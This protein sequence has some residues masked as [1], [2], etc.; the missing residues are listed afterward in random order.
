MKFLT[1]VIVVAGLVTLGGCDGAPAGRNGP[2]AD[3]NQQRQSHAAPLAAVEVVVET[4]TPAAELQADP[5]LPEHQQELLRIAWE[6]STA[7]P[8]NPHLRERARLQED[9]ALHAI[10]LGQL[11]LVR[12]GLDE[13]KTMRRL[14]VVAELALHHARRG[15][16][17]IAAAYGRE[18]EG[19]L[20]TQEFEIWD[21]ARLEAR[22]IAVHGWLAA[23][24]TPV[25]PDQAANAERA[26]Y[27]QSPAEIA[28]ELQRYLQAGGRQ[29]N[30]MT[31][32]LL[33]A[34]APTG[35]MGDEVAQELETQLRGI[36]SKSSLPQR[37]TML[38][39]LAAYEA[40]H[41]ASD[42]ALKLAEEAKAS[43]AERTWPMEVAVPHISRMAA[44]YHR[45]GKAEEAQALMANAAQLFVKDRA[46][47]L[48]VERAQVLLPLAEAHFLCGD[49]TA[50]MKVYHQAMEEAVANPNARPRAND[51]VAVCRSLLTYG[52]EPDEKLLGSIRAMRVGLG[53]PW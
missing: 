20:K 40:D 13:I 25:E 26:L 12:S 28:G 14:T 5:K 3:M 45:A 22:W 29:L 51:L 27:P 6:A 31:H 47:I 35:R 46:L 11:A 36:G 4:A 19:A 17:E 33:R 34:H 30:W 16:A 8:A 37:Y 42:H 48:E 32:T 18:V 15:E 2:V 23:R 53:D 43:L 44:V 39:A 10:Q 38:L 1:L 9:T 7:L 24:T 21:R 52:I 41:G 49:R 50:A